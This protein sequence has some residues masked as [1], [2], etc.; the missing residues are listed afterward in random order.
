LKNSNKCVPIFP[1]IQPDPGATIRQSGRGQAEQ[2]SWRHSPKPHL[3]ISHRLQ[4]V[5]LAPSATCQVIAIG[6]ST[7]GE[8]LRESL[9]F[10]WLE[11]DRLKAGLEAFG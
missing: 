1:T 7:A 3:Q 4:G 9:I 8:E 2:L 10:R 11:A 6:A 5:A